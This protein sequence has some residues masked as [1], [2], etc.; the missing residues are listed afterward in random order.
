MHEPTST[1]TPA[2]DETQPSRP[3]GLGRIAR[4]APFAARFIDG[5]KTLAWVAPLTILI[6]VY[7][8]RKQAIRRESVPIPVEVRVNSKD[9]LVVVRS[10]ADQ[11]FTATLSGPQASVQ[12]VIETIGVPTADRH[13][14]IQITLDGQSSGDLSLAAVDYLRRNPIFVQAGISVRDVVPANLNVTV[15]DMEERVIPVRAPDSLKNVT[16]PRFV[17]SEVTVRAP[18]QVLE[19]ATK[20]NRLYV[21]PDLSKADAINQPGHHDVP[22]VSLLPAFPAEHVTIEPKTVTASFEVNRPDAEVT[23]EYPVPVWPAGP[24]AFMTKYKVEC[25]VSIPNIHIVGPQDQIDLLKNSGYRVVALLY[26]T[27]D[28]L[29]DGNTHRKVLRFDLPPG[30]RVTNDPEQYTVTFT[31]IERPQNE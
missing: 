9:K 10:P 8:E 4:E 1:P 7:A 11:N 26:V 28:D 17:P 29:R 3:L 19:D 13:A 24:T 20:N 18:K 5:L 2:A 30:V 14:V 16:N 23:L 15:Y 27:P 25:P 6:W 21:L 12:R 22:G 31:L